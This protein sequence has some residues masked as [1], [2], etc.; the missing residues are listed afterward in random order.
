M[1]RQPLS[2]IVA[3]AE[4]LLGED[5]EAEAQADDESFC[6]V[7]GY[8]LD[9]WLDY[10]EVGWD[11]PLQTYFLQAIELDDGPVWW[12]GQRPR[13]LSTFEDLC[14]AINRAFAGKVK[15]EFIDTI[16]KA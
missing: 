7:E 8:G 6:D 5:D 1:S 14:G 11:E 3:N 13:E 9:D 15:F 2:S 16:E 12:F 10:A 4:Q